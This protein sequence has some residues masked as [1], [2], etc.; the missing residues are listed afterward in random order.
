MSTPKNKIPSFV[1]LLLLFFKY[2]TFPGL[3]FYPVYKYS[4]IYFTWL[5]LEFR[6][7]LLTRNHVI[8]RFHS[9]P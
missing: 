2:L 4:I 3:Y 5:I 7:E 8:K 9:Y 1:A 6:D